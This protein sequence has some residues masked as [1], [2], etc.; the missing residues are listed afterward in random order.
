MS[1]CDFLTGEPLVQCPND[2]VPELGV[3]IR[4]ASVADLVR[5]CT[6]LRAELADVRA[7]I[8][9]IHDRENSTPAS[10]AGHVP[11]PKYG[12]TH[13]QDDRT[14]ERMFD[15]VRDPHDPEDR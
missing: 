9:P 3:C 4:H 10:R 14:L 8:Q 11:P 6:A 7:M 5:Y 13:R 12:P 15:A 2:I 1:R